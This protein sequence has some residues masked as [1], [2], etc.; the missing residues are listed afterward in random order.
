MENEL[1]CRTCHEGINLITDIDILLSPCACDGT[2]K[3]VHIDCFNE[4]HAQRC[5]VCGLKYPNTFEHEFNFDDL[6][7]PPPP[8][9]FLNNEMQEDRLLMIAQILPNNGLNVHD[10]TMRFIKMVKN[11]TFWNIIVFTWCSTFNFTETR[12][13]FFKFLYYY[14]SIN[15]ISLY[16]S[17]LTLIQLPYWILYKLYNAVSFEKMTLMT[18]IVVTL[19]ANNTLHLLN[20]RL[21]N[22]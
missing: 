4:E 20:E 21:M 17:I 18:I 11:P 6:H 19:Y 13:Y 3:Y 7:I 8:P 12:N 22:K 14:L 5:N 16:F 2:A 1:V 15:F 9:L 10:M